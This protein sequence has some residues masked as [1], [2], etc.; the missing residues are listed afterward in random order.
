[1]PP[2]IL[3][4]AHLDGVLAAR[5]RNSGD[6]VRRAARGK[7]LRRANKAGMQLVACAR[8][9]GVRPKTL[10]HSLVFGGIDQPPWIP[11][12]GCPA[13]AAFSSSHDDPDVREALGDCFRDLG[14]TVVAANDGAHAVECL[15]ES[16]KPCLVLLDLYMPRLDGAGLAAFIRAHKTHCA[17]PIVSMSAGP[18]QLEPPLVQCHRKKPF[19]FYVLEPLIEKFCQDRDWLHGTR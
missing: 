13:R 2:L 16:L 14:C 19:D 8:E 10:T 3:A 18:E 7:K 9:G 17:L 4:G 15:G 12:W 11:A 6:L 1:M 5:R